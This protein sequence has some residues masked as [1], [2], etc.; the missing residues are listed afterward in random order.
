MTDIEAQ[1]AEVEADLMQQD[2]V[3]AVGIGLDDDGNEVIVVTVDRGEARN[4]M[5]PESL[6]DS[7]TIV[8]E[9]EQFT[10][11]VAIAELE[12]QAGRKEKV[13]P[14]P[15]G[16]SAGHENVTAGT[17]SYI[18]TD[19]S[20]EF[21]SSNN[22][23]YANINSGEAG[24]P[25]IQPGSADGG[26]VDEQS[27]N[28]EKYVLIDD[29]VTV[30]LAWANQDVEHTTDLM[31]VGKP[32]GEPRR[33]SVGDQVIKSGRTTGVTRGEVKQTSVTVDVNYGDPGVITL[34]DQFFTSDMSEPGDSGSAV[35]F[36]DGTMNPAGLLFAGSDT[37]TVMNYATNVESES[38]LTIVTGSGSDMPTAT[39]ELQLTQDTQDLGSI[40]ASVAD[41]QQAPIENATV[42]IN[43][44]VNQS[45]TT[46]S[47][48][49]AQFTEVP[50][51]AYTISASKEGYSGDSADITS[52]NFQ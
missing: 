19:G 29:G 44:E 41:S 15:G 13:R 42:K 48:G 31:Q 26:T 3:H 50:I 17:V 34:K 37:T 49:V 28:L 36:D 23:V 32:Q 11:E 2:E 1:K 40:R 33:P 52:D 22:H 20:T 18:L 38:G 27:A 14:V 46:N 8:Q 25:I 7:N 51:G 10:A 35:L 24:D 43:G 4:F 21:T 12:P 45:A 16:V 39:V 5:L 47:S 6:E 9:S 30:D